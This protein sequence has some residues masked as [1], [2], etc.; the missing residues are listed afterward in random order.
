M[1]DKIIEIQYKDYDNWVSVNEA[2]T[3][4]WDNYS[5]KYK[6]QMIQPHYV[7]PV[8]IPDSWNGKEHDIQHTSWASYYFEMFLKGSE[9]HELVK[10]KSCSDIRIVEYSRTTAGLIITKTY[11]VDTSSPEVFIISEPERVNTTSS[12][13]V[14]VIFRTD[15]T[16]I[17]KGK[18]ILDTNELKFTTSGWALLSESTSLTGVNIIAAM[19]ET[20]MVSIN[21]GVLRMHDYAL[22]VWS[23]T[24]NAYVIHLH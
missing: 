22:G 2:K 5:K 13:K 20:R 4:N 10:L 18:S 23:Q 7:A 24:G 11:V 16:V 3:V 17:N 21:A 14:S 9:V 8:V 12:W 6:N 1:T 19:T 15:R